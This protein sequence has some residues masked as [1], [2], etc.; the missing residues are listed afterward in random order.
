MQI[1]P[2]SWDI[3]YREEFQSLFETLSRG[4]IT[5]R[6]QTPKTLII[7]S[8]TRRWVSWISS[9]SWYVESR[10]A[11]EQDTRFP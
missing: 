2:T 11:K 5:P 8:E 3:N 6:Q 1:I 9:F 10:V 7:Q 4:L